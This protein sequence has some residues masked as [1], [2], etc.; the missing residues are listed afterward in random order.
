MNLRT[1]GYCRVSTEEQAT[2]GVSLDIQEERIRAY[3]KAK[4]WDLVEVV[5]DEGISAKNLKRPGL[6]DILKRLLKKKD[7]GFDGIIVHKL[8]R[9][10][11]SVKDLGTL[12]EL[13]EKNGITFVSIQEAVDTSTA[14][15][16]LFHNIVVSISQWERKVI[17]ERTK[18]A[19]RYKRQIGL[20]AGEI[21]Y[22]YRLG[23]DQ[24]SLISIPNEQETIKE[25]KNLRERG[26][27]YEGIAITLNLREIRTKKGKEWF[28]AT[29]HSVLRYAL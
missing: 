17:S 25:I 20:R 29:V 9:L 27:S 6:Q 28:P 7:K 18:S 16:E 21:P 1:I 2:T 8:D 11:R 14:A 12:N 22:G 3:C 5:K 23:S 4:D 24:K 19:L 13:F 15:G 10:T 26:Y